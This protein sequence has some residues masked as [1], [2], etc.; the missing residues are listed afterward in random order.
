MFT[1]L[2]QKNISSFAQTSLI[3]TIFRIE[4]V[5]KRVS[6]FPLVHFLAQLSNDGN[7]PGGIRRGFAGQILLSERSDGHLGDLK[8]VSR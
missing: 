5:F 2:L 8:R 6:P 3:Q 7:I 4:T 1:V